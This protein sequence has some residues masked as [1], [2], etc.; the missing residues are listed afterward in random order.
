[1]YCQGCYPGAITL[2]FN[3]MDWPFYDPENTIPKG[4][5]LQFEK[6]KISGMKVC[7]AMANPDKY[8]HMKLNN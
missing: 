7:A 2:F 4:L 8:E 6:G 1:M 5:A 3:T